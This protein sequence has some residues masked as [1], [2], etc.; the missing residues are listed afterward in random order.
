MVARLGGDEFVLLINNLDT[1][2]DINKFEQSIHQVMND[3]FIIQATYINVTTSIG[4]T[5]CNQKELNNSII[6]RTVDEALYEVKRN[7]KNKTVINKIT[8]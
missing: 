1:V 8:G 6:L 4:I 3:P 5:L 7:G 2:N